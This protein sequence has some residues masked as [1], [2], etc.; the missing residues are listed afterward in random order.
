MLVQ[1]LHGVR[2]NG[3]RIRLWKL[4][5]LESVLQAQLIEVVEHP[6]VTCLRALLVAVHGARIL[7]MQEV[8]ERI[9]YGRSDRR[10]RAQ[11]LAQIEGSRVRQARFL[12]HRAET[13]PSPKGS[14]DARASQAATA[15]SV[16]AAKTKRAL[17]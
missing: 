13:A 5:L 14:T 3:A 8:R 11:T 15:S 9:A 16:E 1:T 2:N 10:T 12:A 6:A 17:R 4:K 7:G